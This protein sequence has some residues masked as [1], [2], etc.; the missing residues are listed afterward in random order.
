VPRR[1]RLHQDRRE[2]YDTRGEVFCFRESMQTQ[3]PR[4]DLPRVFPRLWPMA[5][6]LARQEIRLP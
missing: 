3:V 4:P 2:D 1:R 5:T 6:T